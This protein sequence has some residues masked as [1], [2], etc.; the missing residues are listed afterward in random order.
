MIYN[1]DN[2]QIHTV[3]S[4][5]DEGKRKSPKEEQEK[6]TIHLPKV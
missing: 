2:T 1:G 3:K 4:E 6:E 5:T